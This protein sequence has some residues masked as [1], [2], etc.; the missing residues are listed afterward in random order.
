MR[1]CLPERRMYDVFRLCL[2]ALYSC[3]LYLNLVESAR[4][5]HTH[6]SC[7]FHCSVDKFFSEPVFIT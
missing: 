7:M 4:L 5:V 3:A 6:S 1:T 2:P